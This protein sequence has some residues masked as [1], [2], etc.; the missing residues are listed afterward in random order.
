MK[1]MK[2]TFILFGLF[3]MVFGTVNVGAQ[4]R[5]GGSTAPHKSAVL[6]LNFD[7]GIDTLGLLLPRVNLID[8]DSPNPLPE[9]EK[10]LL[11]Y[12]L[13][14]GG[15][16]D[17]GIYYNNG[18][19]WLPIFSD[20]PVGT[21]SPIIF[22]RQPGFL[23]LG[24][25][26]SSPDTMFVEIADAA[27]ANFTY[28]WYSRD[29]DTQVSSP[30]P[31]ATRDTIFITPT[32]MDTYGINTPGKVYQFYCVVVSG[33]QYAISGTG[34]V[35]YGPGACLAN[36]GW[37][38]VANANL[39]ADQTK[40]LAAQLTYE[41]RA[42]SPTNNKIY[43]P[44]VYGDFYQWGR[45]KDGHQARNVP[46]A[47][48]TYD[49][50]ASKPDGIG[51]DSLTADGQIKSTL[52]DISGKFILRNV[53]T[54][55]DW[56]RYPETAANSETSPADAWTWSNPNNN[57]CKD[58]LGV[59][60]RVPTYTEWAQIQTNNTWIWKDGG[61]NGVS[62]YEIKPSGATKPTAF[63]LPAAGD[64]SYSNGL[65]TTVG[66]SGRYWSATFS[67]SYAYSI[68]ASSGNVVSASINGRTY[69]FAV[70]CVAD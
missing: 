41:P 6:D 16:L 9:H 68:V 25:T 1:M 8:A 15:S 43:D 37:I 2:K 44:T 20:K 11:V 53:G 69:G 63:F 42:L 35:V 60:W 30:I 27:S 34:R 10:G 45:K 58:E 62:G 32:A 55:G 61:N 28:Q 40:S 5:I 54:T 13:S 64:R 70:R 46:V 22:L 59:G 67:G 18:T 21:Q 38:R 23:W 48:I 47:T 50:Y 57:P 52:S 66:T 7:N 56:R 39:G 65:I 36:G 49:A 4:V 17:E 3:L 29:P 31:G 33:S 26:V 12:N 14:G 51:L 19:K 24:E